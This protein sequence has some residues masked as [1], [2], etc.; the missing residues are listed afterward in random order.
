MII[1]AK[2]EDFIFWTKAKTRWGDMDG[3]RHINHAAYLSYMETARMESLE[4]LGFGNERWNSELGVIL[5][6]AKVDY[7]SQIHHPEEL[8]IGLAVPKIGRTSFDLLTGIFNKGKSKIIVQAV[9]VLVTFNY[10]QNKSIPVPKNIHTLS[11]KK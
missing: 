1:K 11:G 2:P 4:Q 8:D 6:S 9:F 3:L 10:N 7:F 5:A